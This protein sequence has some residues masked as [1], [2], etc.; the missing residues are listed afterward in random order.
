MLGNKALNQ[1]FRDTESTTANTLQVGSY[2]RYSGI[3]V[4]LDMLYFVPNSKWNTYNKSGGQTKLL[5]DTKEAKLKKHIKHQILKLT[6][7]L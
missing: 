1:Y 3:K 2:G 5:E 7:V 6:D 4:F